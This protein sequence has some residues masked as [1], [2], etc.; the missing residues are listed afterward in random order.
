MGFWEGFDSSLLTVVIIIVLFYTLGPP[1]FISRFVRGRTP[2]KEM[3]KRL[4]VVEKRLDE[5]EQRVAKSTQS[6]QPPN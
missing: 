2:R 1:E 6:Q 5:L 4:T 3:E